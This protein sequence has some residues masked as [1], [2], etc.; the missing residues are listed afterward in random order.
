MVGASASCVSSMIIPGNASAWEL[1]LLMV[2]RGRPHTVV[3]DNGTEL[4]SMAILRWSQDRRIDW[5]YTAP[6]SPRRTRSSKA[7]TAGSGMNCSTRLCSPHWP[8]PGSIWRHGRTT[9]H[10]SGHTAALA[11]CRLPPTQNSTLPACNGMERLSNWGAPR[12]LPLHHRARKAQMTK[13]LCSRLDE[14]W[15]SRQSRRKH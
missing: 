7:S 10:P 8:T 14:V 9:T 2:Q 11:I 4:T 5:H 3:S 15:G 6:G 1:D 12:S 13:G